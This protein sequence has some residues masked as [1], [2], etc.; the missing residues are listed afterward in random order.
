MS[1]FD[2]NSMT[3]SLKGQ[4]SHRALIGLEVT[5]RAFNH[6]RASIDEATHRAV[7]D[8]V[9]YH[10]PRHYPFFTVNFST[11]DSLIN[12]FTASTRKTP[13]HRSS[14]SSSIRGDVRAMSQAPNGTIRSFVPS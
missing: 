4:V 6:P 13:H 10:R 7:T 2:K 9:T 8:W 1:F 12:S 14:S 11:I 5:V 3:R